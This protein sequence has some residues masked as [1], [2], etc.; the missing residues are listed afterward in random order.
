MSDF[1][2]KYGLALGPYGTIGATSGGSGSHNI[3][4]QFTDGDTT[5]DI[6][7]GSY[8]LTGNAG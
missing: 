8:F 2:I 5:P 4:N 6:S 1:R 3:G 7:L